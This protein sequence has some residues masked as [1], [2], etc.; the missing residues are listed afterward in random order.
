MSTTI[1]FVHNGGTTSQDLGAAGTNGVNMPLESQTIADMNRTM[2]PVD[3]QAGQ[4]TGNDGSSAFFGTHIKE[5]IAII[6]DWKASS[7]RK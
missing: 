3:L 5:G 7:K 6:K 4:E 1:L 2:S